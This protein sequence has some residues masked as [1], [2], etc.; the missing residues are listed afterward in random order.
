[1]IISPTTTR[2]EE[3]TDADINEEIYNRTKNNVLLYASAGPSA[4][5]RRLRDLEVEW[6]IERVLEANA[7]S[8]SLMGLALGAFVDRRWFIFPAAIAGFLL[9]HAIQGWCPPVPLFRRMGIRTAHEIQQERHALKALRGDYR[10]VGEIAG[11][12]NGADAP[13]VTQAF[14]AAGNNSSF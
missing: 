12:L 11:A 1:M 2:V 4:I 5:D 8:F 9:Q 3:H 13:Q 6:D 7:A 14:E 10:D